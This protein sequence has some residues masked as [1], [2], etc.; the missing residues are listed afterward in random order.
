MSS[1][2]SKSLLCNQLGLVFQVKIDDDLYC[3]KKLHVF[4]IT[5][6]FRSMYE[7]AKN[8]YVGINTIVN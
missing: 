5:I 6:I 2:M 4:W 8:N 1:A 7:C 3:L